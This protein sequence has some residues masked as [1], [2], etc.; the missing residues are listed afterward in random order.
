MMEHNDQAPQLEMKNG[1][2]GIRY[3]QN[4]V[5]AKKQGPYPCNYEAEKVR[6]ADEAMRMSMGK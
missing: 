6:P 2:R 5:H 4:F 3:E 1:L